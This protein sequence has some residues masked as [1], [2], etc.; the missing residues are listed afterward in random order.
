MQI[1]PG[2]CILYIADCIWWGKLGSFRIFGSSTVPPRGEIGFVSHFWVGGVMAGGQ[3]G[4]VLRVSEC[5]DPR[6]KERG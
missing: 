4:F 1:G 2:D 6:L 5:G 3:I